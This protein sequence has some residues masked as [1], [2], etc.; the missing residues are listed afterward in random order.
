MSTTDISIADILCQGDFFQ[1]GVY[2][3]SRGEQAGGRGTTEAAAKKTR[4]EAEARKKSEAEREARRKVRDVRRKAEAKK[5]LAQQPMRTVK[6]EQIRRG[7]R[8]I[9]REH[10]FSPKPSIEVVCRAAARPGK[11]TREAL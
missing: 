1:T 7:I 8:T 9:C 3:D 6:R 11:R 2:S 5:A 4:E 10:Q